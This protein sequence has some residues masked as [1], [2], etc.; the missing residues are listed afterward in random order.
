VTGPGIVLASGTVV[1]IAPPVLPPIQA[2][3]PTT[4]ATV[5]VPV[6]GPPGPRGPAG[7]GGAE[8]QQTEPSDVWIV[9]HGL[10][11]HPVAWSLYDDQGRLCDEY[12]VDHP[13]LNRAVVRMDVPTAGTVRM[14]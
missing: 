6:A 14:I 4:A 10:G 9:D 2:A 12:V 11:H 8:H 1:E 7:S 13:T 5:V 3:P